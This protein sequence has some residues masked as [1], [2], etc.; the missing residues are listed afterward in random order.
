MK[1]LYFQDITKDLE[2]PFVPSKTCAIYPVS[3]TQDGWAK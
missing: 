1:H 2:V 3:I